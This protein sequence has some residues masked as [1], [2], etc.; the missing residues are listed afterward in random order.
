MKNSFITL[1][2]MPFGAQYCVI[3]LSVAK[4]LIMLDVVMV[5]VVAPENLA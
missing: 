5:S 3:T 4:K 2:I 1:S